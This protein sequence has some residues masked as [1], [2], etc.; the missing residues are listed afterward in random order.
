M[1]LVFRPE[2]VGKV[3]KIKQLKITISKIAEPSRI[4]F[5][6]LNGKSENWDVI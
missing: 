5:R 3:V 1:T 6:W 4:E 2:I